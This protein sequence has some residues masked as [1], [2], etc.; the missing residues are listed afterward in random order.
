MEE[1]LLP[2][3]LKYSCHGI[4]CHRIQY[5]Y[6]LMAVKSTLFLQPVNCIWDHVILKVVIPDDL[7]SADNLCI[8]QTLLYCKLC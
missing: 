3:D 4:S 8:L 1:F 5:T 6:V 2:L 7:I